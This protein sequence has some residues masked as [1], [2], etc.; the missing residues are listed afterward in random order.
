MKKQP[1]TLVE[2]ILSLVLVGFIVLGSVSALNFLTSSREKV[3]AHLTLTQELRTIKNLIQK[4]LNN[5]FRV[6]PQ[7]K[8]K[9]I[10]MPDESQIGRPSLTFY[11]SSKNPARPNSKES[12]FYEV[13]YS[14]VE[15]DEKLKF[16]RRFWPVPD[17][18]REDLGGV[19]MVLSEN[20]SEFNVKFLDEEDEWLTEWN[21]EM[22]SLPKLV[23]VELS[24]QDKNSFSQLETSFYVNFSRRQDFQIGG[25]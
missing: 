25:L 9:F 3:E 21:E 11:C 12:D 19:L 18:M 1:F 7:N 8:L 4:D 22:K 15:N 5:I 23:E 2:M 17:E 24:V 16:I 13:Q 14:L 20:I 6:L 10:C